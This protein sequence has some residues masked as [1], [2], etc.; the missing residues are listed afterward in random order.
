M[1][2]IQRTIRWRRV[3]WGTLLGSALI[4][5]G[6]A[7]ARP[8]AS[9]LLSDINEPPG[10]VCVDNET[11]TQMSLEEAIEIAEASAC[12][13]DGELLTSEAQCNS[14]SGTWWID[15][16]AEQSGCSPACVVSLNDRTAETN[17][18]CTGLQPL[19]EE[20]AIDTTAPT[21]SEAV[22]EDALPT[23]TPTASPSD[24]GERAEDEA[25]DSEDVA[26]AGAEGGGAESV[27][28][29]TWAKFSDADYGFTFRYP[30]DWSIQLLPERTEGDDDQPAAPAVQLSR[31]TLQI[32][33]AYKDPNEAAVIGPGSLP[34]GTIEQ[35]GS[36]TLLAREV[37]RHVL[38]HE[39][40]DKSAFAG[41][42]FPDI[43]LYIQMDDNHGEDAAAAALSPEDHARFEQILA[44]FSRTA[45][46]GA[47]DPYD[48]WE[49]FT[50]GEVSPTYSADSEQGAGF[51]FRYPADWT[52]TERP[53]GSETETGP[54]A[55]MVA[56]TKEGY[57]LQV[58][59][60]AVGD[61][62][63]MTADELSESVLMEAGAAWFMGQAVPRFV[64]AQDGTLERVILTYNDDALLVSAELSKDPNAATLAEGGI[65]ATI[66]DEVDQI[67]ASFEIYV[68]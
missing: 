67:L 41:D 35:R 68:P 34:E 59:Y 52:L 26:G 10:R 47:G 14:I 48:G 13:E 6:C 64:V 32:L 44:T 56:L 55:A 18:R 28:L 7:R 20:T 40:R 65:P 62:A 15:L 66:R 5:A 33:V 9:P 46:V 21:E 45:P 49:S 53:A 2:G 30:A 39:G 23:A 51:I 43:E 57:R 22:V 25:A 58:Q 50:S 61:E 3:L 17:W 24:A 54:A 27:D 12:M 60:K 29:S 8:E 37:P 4:I 38:V 19:E 11:G 63:A 36:V 1:V 31:G 42:R 16:D